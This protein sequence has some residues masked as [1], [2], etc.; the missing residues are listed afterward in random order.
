MKITG[1]RDPY[2]VD[3]IDKHL[4][5][6]YF[7]VLLVSGYIKLDGDALRLLKAFY[8]GKEIEVKE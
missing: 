2:K 5:A 3:Q 6:D 1:T 8:E 7:W 4:E